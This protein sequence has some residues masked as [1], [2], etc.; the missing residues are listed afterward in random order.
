MH[1]KYHDLYGVCVYLRSNRMSLVSSS[2]IYTCETKSILEGE[3]SLHKICI[4]QFPDEIF[5]DFLFPSFYGLEH[6]INTSTIFFA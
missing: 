1:R 4:N 6:V 2:C 3:T 5:T